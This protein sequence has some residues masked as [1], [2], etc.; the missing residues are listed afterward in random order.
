M[1]SVPRKEP[2]PDGQEWPSSGSNKNRAPPTPPQ[3]YRPSPQ[4]LQPAQTYRPTQTHTPTDPQTYR[5]TPPQTPAKIPST[6][7]IT[8]LS[9]F[10]TFL[11]TSAK[12]DR[13]QGMKSTAPP[14]LE[15]SQ[16]VARHHEMVWRYLRLLGCESALA[17]DLTQE[18]FLGVWQDTSPATIRSSIGQGQRCVLTSRSAE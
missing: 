13:S 14:R 9:K 18:T 16:L 8:I 10:P 11:T 7:A 2:N 6:V 1:K 5:P 17:E 15:F 3:A 4:T 12:L